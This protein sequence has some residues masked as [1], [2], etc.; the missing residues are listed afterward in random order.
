MYQISSNPGAGRKVFF[1]NCGIHAREWVTPAT[2]MIILKQVCQT[3]SQFMFSFY[4]AHFRDLGNQKIQVGMELK[5]GRL[6]T[7]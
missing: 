3:V 5:M 7:L 1:F 6:F 2:C 4:V